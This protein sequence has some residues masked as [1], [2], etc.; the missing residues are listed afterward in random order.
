MAFVVEDGT[1]LTNSNSYVSVD[2]AN[3]YF[4]DINYQPDWFT[5]S[6]D[7]RQRSL[8]NATQYLD[9]QYHYKGRKSKIDQSLAF[10]R[11]DA[12]DKD[13]YEISGVPTV[14]KKSTCELAV[15]SF[16]ETLHQDKSRKGYR[17]LEK[18][19]TI[20]VEYFEN[21][22]TENP[23]TIIDQ[24]LFSSGIAKGNVREFSSPLNVVRY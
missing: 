2:F 14:I 6:T 9:I 10:P 23:Y 3:E 11:T 5:R 22:A 24:L 13:G 7:E 1:G 19:D 8:M 4:T 12:F 18:V 16:S 17:K 21:T 20:E 15:K